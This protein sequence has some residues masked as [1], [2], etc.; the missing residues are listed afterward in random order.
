ML[1]SSLKKQSSRGRFPSSESYL[2]KLPELPGKES[3]TSGNYPKSPEDSRTFSGSFSGNQMRSPEILCRSLKFPGSSL[4]SPGSSLKFP[5]SSPETLGSSPETLGSS[6]ETLGS[7]LETL[8]SSP[9]TSGS[10]LRTSGSSPETLGNDFKTSES[11][12][13][14]KKDSRNFL[15]EIRNFLREEAEKD[16]RI[17][18]GSG[19]GAGKMSFPRQLHHSIFN[20]QSY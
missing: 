5:G 16:G 7:S 18:N 19:R 8:G 20:P 6:P 3:E 15:R 2:E 12:L 10:S 17:G 13:G 11:S 14:M 9:E 1:L 4:K